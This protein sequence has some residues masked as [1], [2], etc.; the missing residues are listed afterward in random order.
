MTAAM[1]LKDIAPW[2]KSYE[3]TRWCIKKT[4]QNK[5]KN[6]KTETSLC[7]PYSQ[8]YGFS[9]NHDKT[10]S[11]GEGNEKP[12]QYCILDN[13]MNSMKSKKIGH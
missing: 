9:K 8:S 11:T 7:C 1:K 10:W 12:L 13:L 4:K 2:K 3:K 6:K 5:N